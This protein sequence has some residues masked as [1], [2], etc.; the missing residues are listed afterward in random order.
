MTVSNNPSSGPLVEPLTRRES[1]ILVFLSEGFSA[2]EIAEQ[3]TIAISSVKFHIQNLYGKL[4]VNSKRQA[5]ARAAELGLLGA[6]PA[7]ASA[8]PPPAAPS[9]EAARQPRVPQ[10]RPRP[11]PRHNLPVQLTNFVGRAPQIMEV[12][13]LLRGTRLLT[14]IGPGGSGK[15]RLA[16]QIAAESLGD[17]ADGAWLVELAPVADPAQVPQAVVRSLAL[18]AETG[19]PLELAP[20]AP[21]DGDAASLIRE[22][23]RDKRLLL[24]LDNCEHLVAASAQLAEQ[25]L[26]AAPGLRVLATSREALGVVGETSYPV[27]ALSVPNLH[28]LPA[29]EVFA[30]SEAIQLFVER[31]KAVRPD[32]DLTH[33]NAPVVAQICQH[34]DGIPLAIELAAARVRALTVEQIAAHLDNRFALLTGGSRTAPPRQQTLRATIEWSYEL[35]TEGERA[36]LRRLSV[37]TGGWFLEAAEQVMNE[38]QALDWLT[39]LV[40]KS[41]VLSTQ[42]LAGEARFSMLETIR[43]YAEE[44]LASGA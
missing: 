3:L 7:G 9:V 12:K 34:L 32:F 33:R 41:L 35:L 39:Q 11:A 17:F 43:Q 10:A 2:P 20:I 14:L 8:G 4:G 37:F 38:P 31:A 36:L 15:T 6:S 16:L 19:L 44:K 5:L 1:E 30:Q 42:P 24:I 29:L 23:L 22:H 18:T 26:R 25:L 13:G 27:P 40:A 28:Q 21:S